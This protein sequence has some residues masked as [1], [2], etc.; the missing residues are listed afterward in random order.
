MSTAPKLQNAQVLDAERRARN[1]WFVDGL[2]DI[3]GGIGCLL[4]AASFGIDKGR[5]SLNLVIAACCYVLSLAVIFFRRDQILEWLKLRVTYPRTGFVPNPYKRPEGLI[6][7]RIDDPAPETPP[8]VRRARRSRNLR[9]LPGMAVTGAAIALLVEVKNPWICL[10]AAVLTGFAF[11]SMRQLP[12]K[13]SLIILLGMPFAGLTMSVLRVAVPQRADAFM[14]GAGTV[15]LIDGTVTL[16]R[17]L[18][19]NPVARA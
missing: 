4:L 18:L 16:I 8:D 6:E 13:E 17:Y 11:C 2:F 19:R 15:F 7:L 14:V 3:L 1:Y 9:T 12:A 10:L 5:S